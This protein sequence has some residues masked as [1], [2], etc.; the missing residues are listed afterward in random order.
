M[1]HSPIDTQFYSPRLPINIVALP[2][3][4]FTA[5]AMREMDKLSAIL[6]T[7]KCARKN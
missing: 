4:D 1:M 2:D 6:Q 5:R 3:S 7:Q